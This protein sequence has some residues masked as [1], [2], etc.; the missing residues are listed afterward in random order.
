MP[1]PNLYLSDEA[2]EALCWYALSDGHAYFTP[3]EAF[4]ALD[5]MYD[6]I[7]KEDIEDGT[8]AWVCDYAGGQFYTEVHPADNMWMP[9]GI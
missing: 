7:C 1:T 5:E 3:H 8:Y 6:L 2:R 9:E 4:D